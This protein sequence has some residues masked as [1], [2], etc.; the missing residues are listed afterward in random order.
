MRFLAESEPVCSLSWSK[1]LFRVFWQLLG[2]FLGHQCIVPILHSSNNPPNLMQH[3][4][5][6]NFLLIN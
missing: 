3:H 1:S 2:M 4:I 5:S 6:N